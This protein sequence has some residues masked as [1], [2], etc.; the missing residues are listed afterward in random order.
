MLSGNAWGAGSTRDLR[1]GGS[2]WGRP[3]F[4]R[5]IF[6]RLG[7]GKT[8]VP[9]APTDAA[10]PNPEVPC[11]ARP[12]PDGVIRLRRVTWC[13]WHPS[14]TTSEG[15]EADST[16]SSE[17]SEPFLLRLHTMQSPARRQLWLQQL[18]LAARRLGPRHSSALP[19]GLSGP[20]HAA[21]RP[22][23]PRI[24]AMLILGY[25]FVSFGGCNG[26]GA[27]ANDNSPLLLSAKKG[28]SRL[29]EAIRKK[30]LRV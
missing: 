4:G 3:N 19:A 23:R 28:N 14:P 29:T 22:P 9:T 30:A 20:R 2:K 18:G 24:V 15:C 25:L 8:S 27:S 12:A 16:R 5:I 21:P 13:R 6:A 11:A 10:E 26:L 17:T 1:E 7:L